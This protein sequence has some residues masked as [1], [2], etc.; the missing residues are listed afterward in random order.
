MYNIFKYKMFA[1]MTLLVFDQV[2]LL[3]SIATDSKEKVRDAESDKKWR[4]QKR[5]KSSS[6]LFNR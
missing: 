2:H 4:Q 5:R 1:V 3:K 6:V